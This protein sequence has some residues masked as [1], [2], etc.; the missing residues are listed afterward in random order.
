MAK[1]PK[2]NTTELEKKEFNLDEFLEKEGLNKSIDTKQLTWIPLSK[3]WHDALKLPGFPR[4]YFSIVRGFTNTGKSTAFY[5]AIAGAQAIG[6][7]PVVIETEGNWNDDHARQIGV[8]YRESV[9]KD[10]GEVLLKPEFPIMNNSS[11]LA[12]YSNY[13]YKD[14]KEKSSPTRNVPV[15][16]DVI[17]FISEMLDKQNDGTLPRNL[18]FIWDSIGTLNCFKSATS[19][20]SNNQWNAGAMGGFQDILNHRIPSTRNKDSKYTN[21]FIAVQKIWID[22]MNGGGIKHRGGEFMFYN[23]RLIVHLGGQIAHG[24]VKLNAEALGQKFQYGIKTKIKCEKNHITGLERS[25]S[26]CS[27]PHG[28]INP[29]ELTN[30]KKEHKKFIHDSLNVDY[31]TKINFT[32]EDGTH[33]ES[34][35]VEGD[36]VD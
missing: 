23:S 4:G 2:K 24:T 36:N 34:D 11:L 35:I 7:L 13:D 22:N 21:T 18:C 31:D 26:I 6:D 29:D 5:E 28:F 32:N 25:G 27:T 16:E 30:Y 1:R 3:A 15:I 8:K 9:D 14:S 19:P 17:R 12:R 20:V 10:T 33:S